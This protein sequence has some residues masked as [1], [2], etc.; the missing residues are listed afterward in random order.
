MVVLEPRY[1]DLVEDFRRVMVGE[2][3][4]YQQRFFSDNAIRVLNLS[5]NSAALPAPLRLPRPD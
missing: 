1:D 4:Q 5:A 2:L 3:A